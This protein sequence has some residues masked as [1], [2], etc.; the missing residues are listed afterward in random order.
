MTSSLTSLEQHRRW[1]SLL[2]D[3]AEGLGLACTDSRGSVLLSNASDDKDTMARALWPASFTCDELSTACTS[4]SGELPGEVV[5][6]VF[7]DEVVYRS[8]ASGYGEE[9]IEY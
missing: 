3:E 4:Y 6:L 9:N 5:Q 1:L 8:L 7:E 2:R